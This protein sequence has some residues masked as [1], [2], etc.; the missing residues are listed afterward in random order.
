MADF[1]IAVKA[2]I[3]R[4]GKLLVLQRNPGDTHYAGKWDLPGGRLARAEEPISGLKRET[5]EETGLDIE[6]LIPLKTEH[7]TREDGEIIT[8][9]VFLCRPLND[10]ITLSREHTAY[11]WID[12]T[13]LE[14][15]PGWVMGASEVFLRY[16]L[17]RFVEAH[18]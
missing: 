8:M 5:R 14:K 10:G 1:G 3:V 12:V 15:H 2:F 6:P 4:D 7:F 17:D 11:M 13:E 9:I 16:G 18:S